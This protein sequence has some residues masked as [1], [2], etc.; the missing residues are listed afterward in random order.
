MDDTTLVGIDLGKHSFHLHGQDR[1]GRTLFRKK[2]SRKQ[3][4]EFFATFHACIVV[5]EACAG[6]HH[7]AHKLAAF[8]HTVKLISPQFVRPFVKSNKNDFV[9]P[10]AICEA[11]SRPTMR[12]VTPKTESQQ[13]LSVLHRVRDS[14]VRDRTRTVNQMHGFLLEFGLSLPVGNSVV[15][16]LPTVLA[17]H[18]LPPRLIAILERLH[19]HFKYLD[20]QIG[21][22]GQELARQLA[23]DDIGQRLMSI[24]GIGPITAS[25]LA[26]EMGD[27]KQY[28]CSRDFA[29]SVGLVPRQY[30]KG[31][32]ANLLGISRRGDRSVRRLLVLC[33][34]S[35]M[36][37]IDKQ[38]GRLAEWVRAMLTRRHSNV[39]ACALAN[40]LARTAWAIVA[41]HTAFNVGHTGVPA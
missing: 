17:G 35:Y 13:T 23:D 39:V 36:R 40:K 31:G 9:D 34:R 26:A 16:R 37:C 20:E 8:G 38:T 27:G 1:K 30:S 15:K 4:I 14:L 33:A 7:M 12:F 28:G 29:A 25:V 32:K 24:P 22:I 5:I 21:E 11:A 6:S 19:E 10:E 3:L 41:H 2:L 18:E